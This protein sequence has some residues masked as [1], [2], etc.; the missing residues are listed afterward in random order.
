MKMRQS[1]FSGKQMYTIA[2]HIKYCENV[3]GLLFAVIPNISI[4]F[5]QLSLFLYELV[6]WSSHGSPIRAEARC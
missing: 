3:Q 5:L 4:V 6:D 1:S 2:A